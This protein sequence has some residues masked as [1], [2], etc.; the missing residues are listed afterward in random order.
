M[1]EAR[2]VI[3]APASGSGK[4]T[5][6]CALLAALKLRGICA[7]S[8]KCGP[9][10]IDPLFHEQVIGVPSETLDLFFSE[11]ADLRRIVRR[12]ASES[13]IAVIEGVMGYYDGLGAAE[14]TA[15]TYRVAAALDAPAVLVLDARGQSLSAIAVLEGFLKFRPDSRIRGVI[16][17]RMSE[18]V[19]L[20]LQKEVE[21]LGIVPLGYLPRSEDFVI[22]SRHLGLITPDGIKDLKE[23]LSILAKTIE[24]TVDLDR[25][26]ALAK[27]ASP[28]PENGTV[29]AS[30][31]AAA[32]ASGRDAADTSAGNTQPGD[33]H[34]ASRKVRIA[35]A[36]DE[37]FCFWYKDN[38]R[39][40]EELGA[41]I[42]FFSPIRDAA[43]P[44]N[45]QGLLLPGGYPELFA[46]KLAEN[47]SM[48][49]SVREAVRSGLPAIAECG[50]FLYLHREIEDM[51]GTYYP[52]AGV[53]DAKAWRTDRLGR[54]GYVTL[55]AK[56][57]GGL[58]ASG[59][60]I[61]GHE[62][63]YYESESCGS[64]L[65]AVK[66]DGRSRWDC[67]HMR[68]N[69]LALFPHLYFGSCPQA[70]ER[71]VRRCQAYAEKPADPA[72]TGT[73]ER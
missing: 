46:R 6:T 1:S 45:I 68:G 4:T 67:G 36:K 7:V 19:F 44:E 72:G 54:F 47:V 15:S 28:L 42:V 39:M 34:A 32:D 53:L 21:R 17:N 55:R 30:G 52:M 3:A 58:L 43:L 25:L 5:V 66:P 26:L 24:H 70:A 64:D 11:P 13:E 60:E 48:R 27:T 71:F 40:L 41:E 35:A 20:S 10:Y 61:R 23:K 12:H 37:A 69:L 51:D 2:I 9:D 57:G 16:F 18:R 63:H 50:G 62:F 14:D 38:L 22:G 49:N 59:E 31:R 8:F 56:E 33:T 29:C 73:K 65:S